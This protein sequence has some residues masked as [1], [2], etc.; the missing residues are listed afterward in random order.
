MGR[1][2]GMERQKEIARTANGERG[3]AGLGGRARCGLKEPSPGGQIYPAYL[4]PTHAHPMPQGHAA[5]AHQ[6]PQGTAAPRSL[7]SHLHQ[8]SPS[9]RALTLPSAPGGAQQPK[10][11]S[12]GAAKWLP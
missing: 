11:C 8:A 1:Q 2:V 5:G 7:P 3:E 12:G 6:P 10:H 9:R 4:P